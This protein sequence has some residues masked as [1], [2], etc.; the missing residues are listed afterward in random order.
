M[1]A[2]SQLLGAISLKNVWHMEDSEFFFRTSP[3]RSHVASDEYRLENRGSLLQ[4][5]KECISLSLTV[6]ADS[7]KVFPTRCISSS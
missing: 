6:N 1:A 4:K 5:H 3:P 7:R 2:L